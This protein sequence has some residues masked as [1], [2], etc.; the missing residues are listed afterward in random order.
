MPSYRALKVISYQPTAS[1][2]SSDRLLWPHCTFCIVKVS[3]IFCCR[4]KQSHKVIMPPHLY[5]DIWMGFSVVFNGKYYSF[6][7]YGFSLRL[8]SISLGLWLKNHILCPN[9]S[10]LLDFGYDFYFLL[11]L[12]KFQHEQINLSIK[13]SIVSENKVYVFVTTHNPTR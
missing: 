2:P 11:S 12:F 7:C 13:I 10:L 4:A 8:Q 3:L 5:P 9:A 1:E 6:T